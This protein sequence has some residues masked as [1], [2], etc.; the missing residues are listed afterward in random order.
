M[1][2]DEVFDTCAKLAMLSSSS[3]G[4][5]VIEISF[6]FWSTFTFVRS[7]SS[8]NFWVFRFGKLVRAKSLRISDLARL[9]VGLVTFTGSLLFS[10][11][12]DLLRFL[13]SFIFAAIFSSL[14]L[15]RSAPRSIRDFDREVVDR[16]RPRDRPRLEIESKSWIEPS[17]EVEDLV[18]WPNPESIS[19]RDEGIEPFRGWSKY[20]ARPLTFPLT[21]SASRVGLMFKFFCCSNIFFKLFTLLV[22]GSTSLSETW[23]DSISTSDSDSDDEEPD[24]SSDKD[25]HSRRVPSAA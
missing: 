23:M 13:G 14:A 12:T 20:P 21:F 9:E 18:D 2:G 22:V 6:L 15:A 19:E 3:W 4:E 24:E 17:N 10:G 25:I 1:V 16:G 8:N 11:S 7:N 5:R